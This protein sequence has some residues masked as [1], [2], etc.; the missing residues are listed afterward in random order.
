[1]RAVLVAAAA[2]VLLAP[3]HSQVLRP[4]LV[5]DA[6]ANEWLDAAAEHEPGQRDAALGKIAGWDPPYF[7]R[8]IQAVRET[9]ASDE[10]NALLERAALLHADISLLSRESGEPPSSTGWDFPGSAT[11]L[12]D[13][14]A[15]GQRHLDPHIQ[16][17]RL[18]LDAI[19][20]PPPE[21]GERGDPV[22]ER[23]RIRAWEAAQKRGPRI[24]Q[25]YRAVTAD[26]ARRHWLADLRPHLAAARDALPNDAD[27]Q[28]DS[29][30]F[31]ET[32]ASPPIQRG[33]PQRH[34]AAQSTGSLTLRSEDQGLLLS[35]AY[36]LAEAEK[37]FR[38]AIALDPEHDETRVR[39]A[40]VRM[41]RGSHRDALDLLDRPLT[42]A[43][44]VVQYYGALVRGG[45]REREG[46]IAEAV[47]DYRRAAELFRDAQSPLIGLARLSRELGDTAALLHA[48]E[49][50]ARLP[51]TEGFRHDPWWLYH[52]CSGRNDGEELETLWRLFRSGASR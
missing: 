5:K 33:L 52:D 3:Q 46:L 34:M 7:K 15:I 20:L 19:R 11:L 37:H 27:V 35:E 18:V 42:S 39:L 48:S 25:W 45:A 26:F 29:G 2:W 12:L 6:A 41:L 23:E 17:G 10:L 38:A 51:L 31:F 16:F 4:P 43:D 9:P 22:A 14:R 49:T 28:F 13:G 21:P 50:M 30:C 40:R 8:I 36:N 32:V 1:M 24:R 44:P 47:L